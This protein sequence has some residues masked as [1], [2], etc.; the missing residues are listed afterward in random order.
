[1]TDNLINP[2]PSENEIGGNEKSNKKVFAMFRTQPQRRP[3]GLNLH[4]ND[5]SPAVECLPGLSFSPGK[6]SEHP[7]KRQRVGQTN[8]C[9]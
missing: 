4:R 3:V 7:M 1:M 2:D 8:L 5:K 9:N 6:H